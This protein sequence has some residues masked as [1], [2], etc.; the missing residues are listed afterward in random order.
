MALLSPGLVIEPITCNNG[1][2]GR[3]DGMDRP[4]KWVAR[5]LAGPHDRGGWGPTG[6]LHLAV[7][8]SEDDTLD[9]WRRE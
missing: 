2:A 5:P 3:D 6:R 9:V 8:E 1:V 7:P 4:A